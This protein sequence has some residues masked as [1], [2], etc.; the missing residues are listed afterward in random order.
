M[1]KE[2]IIKSMELIKHKNI[3]KMAYTLINIAQVHN[4]YDFY[5]GIK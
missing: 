5:D 3:I 4:T 1:E 2:I